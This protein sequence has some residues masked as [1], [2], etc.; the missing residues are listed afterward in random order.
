MKKRLEEFV[1]EI[2]SSNK[3]QIEMDW[4]MDWVEYLLRGG[5]R[6]KRPHG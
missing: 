1:S 6:P 4:L 2:K 5:D 3:K